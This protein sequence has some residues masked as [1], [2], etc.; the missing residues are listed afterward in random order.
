M[1]VL[2]ELDNG[3]L[4]LAFA[5][6]ADFVI[7]RA[8]G[9]VWADWPDAL[10]IDD[11]S[12]Y[13][14][15]P[16]MG[17]VSRLRGRVCLHASAVVVDDF[18]VAI[19]GPPGAGKSTTAAA[20]A[21]AGWPVMADDIVPITRRDGGFDAHP[22][23]PRLRLWP[24]SV[25]ALAAANA[26]VQRPPD[27]W[28]GQRWHLDLIETGF[29]FAVTSKPLAVVFILGE[30]ID[31]ERPMIRPLTGAAALMTLVE[32]SFA[33]T[34]FDAEMRTHDLRTLSELAA[35]LPIHE[36]RPPSD[37]VHLPAVVEDIVNDCRTLASMSRLTR[38]A[39]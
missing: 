24:K 13:L 9:E 30:R 34:L 18:A 5:D 12:S 11:M 2:S 27:D 28:T 3:W 22:G 7:D 35:S 29:S 33:S 26:R 15:G 25:S 37:I 20:F 36:V 14:L 1:L 17:F 6:G 39:E 8:G 31:T 19:A 10:T 38:G 4:R 21:S 32:H 23:Y 16:V